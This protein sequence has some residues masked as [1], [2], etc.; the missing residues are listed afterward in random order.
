MLVVA[1]PT[2]FEAED[3]LPAIGK[4]RREIVEGL[5]FYKGVLGET[6]LVVPIL[7]IGQKFAIESSRKILAQFNPSLLI[8]AGFAGA[9]VPQLSRGQVVIA[10]D[11]THPELLQ[12]MKLISGYDI[13]RMYTS[14]TVASTSAMKA[15]LAAE[16]KCHAVD[17]ETAFVFEEVGPQGIP[18]MAIRVISD[19]ADEDLPSEAL[20][21]G[22]D[23]KKGG[24]TPARLALYLTTHPFQAPALLRFVKTLP[25][26]RRKL[27]DILLELIPALP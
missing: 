13:V 16:T 17:M 19:E 4:S 26:I 14:P 15:H 10:S 6:P 11:F 9:L 12:S 8:I 21:H 18:L 27:T 22:Y 1:F 5:E 20:A 7:G 3:F 25:P 24:P 23:Y 2:R